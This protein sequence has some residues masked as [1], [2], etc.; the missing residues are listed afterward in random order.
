MKVLTVAGTR[1]ELI[2]LSRL[3][4]RLDEQA[5]HVFVHTGQNTGNDL[6]D[7]FFDELRLREPDRQ[8]SLPDASVTRRVAA[9]LTGID[10]I[11]DEVR[12]DHVHVLMD[13]RIVASGGMEIVELLERDGYESFRAAGAG[14]AA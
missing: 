3:V 13:G 11:I 7:Q 9:V 14:T 1:P 12:P 6:R 8:L 2:R 10:D 5:D 4:P